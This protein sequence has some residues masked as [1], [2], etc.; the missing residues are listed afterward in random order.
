MNYDGLLKLYKK[1]KMRMMM[2]KK[3]KMMKK[4]KRI[5]MKKMIHCEAC[6]DDRFGDKAWRTG[7]CNP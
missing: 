1:K 5:S 3:I 6:R 2:M 7:G 4:M